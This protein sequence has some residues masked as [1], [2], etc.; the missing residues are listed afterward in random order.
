MADKPKRT[1]VFI[2]YSHKDA[3]A[4]ERLQVHLKPLERQGIV[5]RWDD[6]QI[7][8]GQDWRAEIE[9]AL[10]EA[11]V[12]ILLVS[13]DFL[14]SD[15]IDR[16]ELPPILLAQKQEGLDV[17]PVILKPCR[18][19]R[20]PTLKRFQSVNSP[21]KPLLGLP[22]IEQENVWVQ[23]SNRVEDILE[24]ANDGS[25]LN[26]EP[27][28][29]PEPKPPKISPQSDPV[30]VSSAETDPPPISAE[31]VDVK[32]LKL[33]ALKAEIAGEISNA[34]LLW[35]EVLAKVPSDSEARNE[36][37]RIE[38][39]SATERVSSKPKPLQDF[40]ED[41]GNGIALEMVAIPGG[42][43]LMG[44]PENEEGRYE[45]EGPQ[46]RVTV[47]P[48]WMGKYPVTQAQYLTVMGQNPSFFKDSDQL[49][50]EQ[51]SWHD[52]Q[53][54]CDRLSQLTERTYRL[55]SEAEW[56]YACRAGTTTAYHFGQELTSHTAN[57]GG[58]FKKTTEVGKFPSNA[59][60]L[61]DMHGNAW[62]W[63][64][65]IW[66]E[67][68]LG[69]PPG[70]TPWIKG[71]D[72]SRRVLRGGSWDDDPWDCRSAL[73]SRGQP[74]VRVINVGFRVVCSSA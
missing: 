64:A 8:A 17:L 15:F 23:L 25:V 68:Y 34:K 21:S 41:L 18:F 30:K 6:T 3:S 61:Y 43:L 33:D 47:S 5:E 45:N 74:D 65:D 49:P 9:R 54:F 7:K 37:A 48:F 69:A 32:D 36:L 63:C 31:L 26:H 13:A 42:D 50:V 51:V 11:R 27:P 73:R 4:L 59:F 52:A 22:D 67:N 14:A 53:A 60:G 20:T 62:E 19:T 2:S 1:K 10:A 55:P 29:V 71:G 24:E 28:V 72:S 70:G 38:Q 56:E 57:F 58:R 46:H 35:N 16:D 40:T 12:A 39:L 66:H 44:S